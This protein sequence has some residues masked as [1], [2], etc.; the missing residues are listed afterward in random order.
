MAMKRYSAFPKAPALWI[1]LM[2]SLPWSIDDSSEFPDSHSLS[3]FLSLSLS[4]S[5]SFFSLS[6]HLTLSSIAPVW[7][8][9]LHPASTQ[10]WSLPW[11][12]DDSSEFP[13]S[14]S[15]SF[16]LSLSL[17]L[18]LLLFSLPPSD[19]IFHP[20]RSSRPH[21]VSTQNWYMQVLAA[22]PTL[23]RLYL[24]FPKET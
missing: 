5:L 17:S 1:T 18:S 16:S 13:D 15:L 12:I 2:S 11:S 19:P 14:H 24:G 10:N 3:L 22:R 23:V 20:V 21:P 9:R 7:S 4:L 6:L 8:S